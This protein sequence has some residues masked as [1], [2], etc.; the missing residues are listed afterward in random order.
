MGRGSEFVQRNEIQ[1]SE[2]DTFSAIVCVTLGLS[3]THTHTL[4][5]SL[6]LSLA[7]PQLLIAVI[8]YYLIYYPLYHCEYGKTAFRSGLK[9]GRGPGLDFDVL[10]ATVA[11]PLVHCQ[12]ARSKRVSVSR[13]N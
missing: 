4:S 10:V 6:S 8:Y 3:H 5:R 11:R 1:K 9:F 12:R 7:V 2:D 13:V